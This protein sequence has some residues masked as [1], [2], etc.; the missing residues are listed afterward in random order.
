[1]KPSRLAATTERDGL[2][3][4]NLVSDRVHFSPRWISIVGCDDHEVGTTLDEWFKRVHQEDQA[5]VRREIDGHLSGVTDEFHIE[6][7]LLHKNGTY[8]WVSCHGVIVRGSDGQPLRLIGSHSETTANRVA[9]AQTGLP[10]RVLFVDRLDA[11]VDRAT[12][13]PLFV[14]AVL[15]IDIDSPS[16][17]GRAS[18]TH[19]PS[20]LTAAARRLETLLRREEHSATL[21]DR[22]LLARFV[23]N[24]FGLLLEGL[25]RPADVQAA[26]KRI[27]ADLLVPFDAQRRQI[28]LQPSIGVAVSATGYTHSDDVLRDA[29]AALYRARSFG[30]G[31]C[32]VFDTEV[33]QSADAR[34][35]LESDLSGALDRHE[36][37]LFFQPIVSIDTHRIV[38]FEALARWQHPSRGMVSPAEFIPIAERTGFIVALGEWVLREACLQL[39]AWQ[40][41][42]PIA[43]DV[44]VSVNVSSPQTRQRSFVSQ[45][46]QALRAVGLDPQCLVLELTESVAIEA[47]EAIKTVLMQ[48]RSIGVRISLDDFGTGHSSLA[49]LHQFPAD[50]LKLDQSFARGLEVR[51]DKVDILNA[52][53]RLATELG[54]HVIAEG[55]ETEEALALL[56][57]SACQSAQGFLFSRPVS[58]DDAANLLTHGLAIVPL[59]VA[60]DAESENGE[61]NP[62]PSRQFERQWSRRL[63]AVAVGA[64]VVLASAWGLAVFEFHPLP[65]G[66]QLPPPPQDFASI[67]PL[68]PL[69]LQV[70]APPT[71]DKV[72]NAPA[73]TLKPAVSAATPDPSFRTVHQHRFGSCEGA[74]VVS[75]GSLSYAADNGKDSFSLDYTRFAPSLND[76]TL[77]I[78]TA[79]RTYRFE[80]PKGEKDQQLAMLRQLMEHIGVSARRAE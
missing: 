32:E 24:H 72:T 16:S 3:E 65:N 11:A 48:L 8:L 14:Y 33:L 19:H 27:L 59:P 76:R 39:K 78:K 23:D 40:T 5:R 79:D 41:T 38:G 17:G 57:A 63:I 50:F 30:G 80:A 61:A 77:T 1:M 20:L 28:F 22:Y 26:A 54:L 21:G 37:L 58:A 46:D 64:M 62:Q 66:R 43:E 4:W 35:Q 47:P 12:R 6:H 2:W 49:Y 53:A 18:P 31:R 34:L 67:R 15:L 70:P 52:I 13:D 25:K 73:E 75:S 44:W 29:D 9:D 36:L 74:L 71:L 55:I 10:N 45:V 60:V 51:R 69:S 42:L 56:R 68:A 7:R